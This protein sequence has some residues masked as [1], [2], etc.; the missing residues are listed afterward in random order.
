MIDG[1]DL[2]RRAAR[3]KIGQQKDVEAAFRKWR[4]R[5]LLVFFD[6]ADG[7]GKRISMECI[8]K[9]IRDSWDEGRRFVSADRAAREDVGGAVS[10]HDDLAMKAARE[11]RDLP[12]HEELR[13]RRELDAIADIIR[14]V[15]VE[16]ME[17]ANADRHPARE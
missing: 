14:R 11:I 1:D 15:V 3:E 6:Q 5:Y 8:D 16:P 2:V 13:G 4:D 9:A 17:K 10:D 12:T 7:V